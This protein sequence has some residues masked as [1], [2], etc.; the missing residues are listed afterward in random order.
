MR[1]PSV[2]LTEAIVC[3]GRSVLVV[4][5]P[6]GPVARGELARSSKRG[7]WHL[8][9]DSLQPTDPKWFMVSN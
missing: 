1:V 8:P 2:F 5:V 4:V 3:F 6:S 9:L 7:L